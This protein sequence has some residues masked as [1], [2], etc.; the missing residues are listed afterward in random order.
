MAEV[1]TGKRDL[2]HFSVRFSVLSCVM[3]TSVRFVVLASVMFCVSTWV[4][5]VRF[6]C[7]ITFLNSISVSSVDSWPLGYLTGVGRR[8]ERDLKRYP[9]PDP[10]TGAS[11]AWAACPWPKFVVDIFQCYC[12]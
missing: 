5:G 2:T 7:S 4:T 6:C 10:R 11:W 1:V 8:T 3:G 12:D 9:S